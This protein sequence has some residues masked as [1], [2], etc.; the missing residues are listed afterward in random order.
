M[1]FI[2]RFG[3]KPNLKIEKSVLSSWVLR[4][5]M[6]AQLH[7]KYR[8][9]WIK[10]GEMTSFDIKSLKMRYEINLRL[11]TLKKCF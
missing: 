11:I 9:C 1:F 6:T 4:S 10:N 8:Y 5:A 2:V 7:S 3:S